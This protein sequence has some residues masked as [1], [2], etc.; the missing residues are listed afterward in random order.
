MPPRDK[1]DRDDIELFR[2][3]IG[4]VKPVHSD[5]LVPRRNRPAPR[6]RMAEKEGC[7]YGD[8]G[9]ADVDYTQSVAAE[10]YLFHSRPGLQHRLLN[11]LRRGQ[12]A[13]GAVLDLHGMTV[14]QARQSL[15]RFLQR[16]RARRI[17]V[18]LVIHGKG[19]SAKMRGGVL[20]SQVNGWLRQHHEV[21][22]FCS[23]QPADGGTGAVYVL[24]ST[25]G[26]SDR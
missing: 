15:G 21:L 13:V 10:Q 25:K 7:A 26:L 24:L 17:R 19:Y 1:P 14:N 5:K 8:A 12:L 9:L 23:A 18:V 20:K 22:A 2:R 6:P 11:R 4:R 3:S 16:S